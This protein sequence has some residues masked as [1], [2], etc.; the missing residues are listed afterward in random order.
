[1]RS[2][3]L[4]RPALR[5]ARSRRGAGRTPARPGRDPTPSFYPPFRPLG[6]VAP[7]L[8]SSLAFY[9]DVAGRDFQPSSTASV[10]A[11][12]VTLW[13][14]GTPVVRLAPSPTMN[15]RRGRSMDRLDDVGRLWAPTDAT[16]DQTTKRPNDDR[17]FLSDEEDRVERARFRMDSAGH[18]RF[19]SDV[20]NSSI[21]IA[22]GLHVDSTYEFEDV[23][24]SL[25]QGP[26]ALE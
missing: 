26:L 18:I 10:A 17:L 23:C 4:P 19:P 21:R 20:P 5:T 12:G 25:V 9:L 8:V 24:F 1:M 3:L 14:S 2:F 11:G 15:T 6:I 22:F 13:L 7:L 16:N